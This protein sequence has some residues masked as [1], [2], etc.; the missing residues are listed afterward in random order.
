MFKGL[1]DDADEDLEISQ[2]IEEYTNQGGTILGE[3]ICAI[4]NLIWV[5]QKN[6]DIAFVSFSR[7]RTMSMG[8][9]T[10][11][12]LTIFKYKA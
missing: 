6:I 10:K 1:E 5:L 12:T 2:M 7:L 9:K 4:G 8:G 11:V 3:L